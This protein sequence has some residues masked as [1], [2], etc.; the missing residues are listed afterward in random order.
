M[1]TITATRRFISKVAVLAIPGFPGVTGV[2]GNSVT[3]GGE[4]TLGNVD[5]VTVGAEGV[6]FPPGVVFSIFLSSHSL[7]GA[8]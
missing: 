6:V 5:A 1:N 4:V 3:L 2:I 8:R 7:I